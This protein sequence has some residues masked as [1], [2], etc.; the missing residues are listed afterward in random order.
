MPTSI[1][2]GPFLSLRQQQEEA[3]GVNGHQSSYPPSPAPFSSLKS[4]RPSTAHSHIYS[5]IHTYAEGHN[6]GT[7][8]TNGVVETVGSALY[9]A[10]DDNALKLG[11]PHQDVLLLHGPRQKY[12]LEKSKEIPSLKGDD[13]LL[14]Q[15]LAVGL[16]PADW[17]GPDYN[18]GHPSDP[19]AN[20]RDFAGLVVRAPRK[21]SRVQSGD[22]VFGPSTDYRDVRKAAY[23]EYVVTA[24]YN[25]ARIP[26][27]VSVKTGAAIGVAFVA[28]AIGLGSSLGIDFSS[29]AREAPLGPDLYQL[30]RSF[31]RTHIPEDVRA[32][33]FDG[34]PFDERPVR[35]DWIAI[36]G[37]KSR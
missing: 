26:K 5:N 35:N 27:G 11:A 28:A 24:D 12:A 37:G 30:V 16:N 33:V 15:V 8:G 2:S 25:V 17:N 21:P 13:E 1:A 36:W 22:V 14:I 18:F 4:G 32:E 19:W 29:L 6:N 3:N 20:G 7:N 34:I 10:D 23:Q 31:D 9:T